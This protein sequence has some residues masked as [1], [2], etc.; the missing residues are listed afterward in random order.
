MDDREDRFQGC[1]LGGAIGDALGFPTENL[2]R[3]RIRQVYGR[4]TDYQIKP[5]WAYYTD[6]TQMAILLAEVLAEHQRFVA[7]AFRRKLARWIVVP[8]RLGGRS[9]KN[10]AW[11]A[12]FGSH[13]TGQHVPGTSG[14]M[15]IAPLAL[16]YHND[17]DALLEQTVACCRVTHTHPAAIAGT[18]LA[19]FSVAYA[20]NHPRF[21]QDEF[22]AYITTPAER[23]DPE[24]AQ[25]VR[26]LPALL[27]T[28][29]EQVFTHLLSHSNMFGSPIADV[30]LAALYAFLKTPDDFSQSVLLC[31]NAGWDTDTMA[32]ICGHI[33]GAWNG[34]R[35]IPPHWIANLENGYK[36]RDY[37]IALA[38]ALYIGADW[39]PTS[40][41]L[42][43]YLGDFGRNMAF[44][45][46]LLRRKRMF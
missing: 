10:A 46:N 20:L 26:G 22:L 8:L 43:D 17:L 32:C 23:F 16:V 25:Q 31:V 15:R 34:L 30:I 12:L 3:E 19:A 28:P 13:E 21:S 2:S 29:E 39:K 42:M 14:A 1:L 24:L 11:R 5:Q 9:T 38:H 35:G 33:S 41:G 7:E 27:D 40:N 45:A 4:L 36:G 44:Q 18:I 6:D 37:I